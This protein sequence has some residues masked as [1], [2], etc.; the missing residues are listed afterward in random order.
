MKSLAGLL[1]GAALPVWLAAACGQPPREDPVIAEIG[2][3][4]VT[5]SQFE[6][7]VRSM[8]DEQAPFAQGELKAELLNQYIDEQLVLLAADAEGIQVDPGVVD[9]LADRREYLVDGETVEADEAG[10]RRARARMDLE[11]HLRVRKLLDEKLLKDL[12]VDESEIAAYYEEN[13][14]FYKRPEAVDVS[15]I[16]VETREEAQRILGELKAEP[17]RFQEMARQFSTGP[18]ALQDGHLGT[19]RKG[20]LPP[21]L[22]E[23]VFSL[24]KGSLSDVVETDFGFHIFRTNDVQPARDLSLEEVADAIRVELLREKS[25]EVMADYLEKLKNRYPVKVHTERL[26]F[27]YSEQDT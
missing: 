24:R 22:E 17:S 9:A 12:T 10:E 23:K 11:T 18:E 14:A 7:Y 21:S 16:L 27:P 15:Q 20:E 3:R 6:A 8:V 5:R 1:A 13:R 19:F 2:D 4:T 26:D 25:D